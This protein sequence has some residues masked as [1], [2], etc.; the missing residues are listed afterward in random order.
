[1]FK[2]CGCICTKVSL[3]NSNKLKCFLELN[4]EKQASAIS[5]VLEGAGSE[6]MTERPSRETPM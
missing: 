1:M 3:R 2:M 6:F 4:K 5:V